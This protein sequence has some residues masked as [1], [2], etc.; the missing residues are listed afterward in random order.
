MGV[1]GTRRGND[2]GGDEGCLFGWGS[3]VRHIQGSWE[4]VKAF[5]SQEGLAICLPS[6]RTLEELMQRLCVQS[7]TVAREFRLDKM[8]HR[9]KSMCLQTM[10]RMVPSILIVRK[11]WRY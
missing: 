7:E 6:S 2:Y 10:A 3:V 11:S 8:L 1:T 4:S 5:L 9:S